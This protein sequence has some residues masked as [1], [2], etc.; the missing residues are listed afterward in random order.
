MLSNHSRVFVPAILGPSLAEAGGAQADFVTYTITTSGSGSLGSQVFTNAPLSLSFVGDTANVVNVQPNVFYN[1]LGRATVTI[2]GLGTATFTGPIAVYSYQ[3]GAAVGFFN[4][5][6]FSSRDNTLGILNLTSSAFV[7]YDLMTSFGPAA[8]SGFTSF[9]TA[10][11][12]T[13]RGAFVLPP[14]GSGT[15]TASLSA[16]PEPGSIVMLSTGAFGLIRYGWRR[17]HR[18]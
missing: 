1:S 16:V 7:R 17:R 5:S 4:G 13:D 10:G 9:T 8:G 11:F 14:P 12:A 6:S 2:V 3:P 18:V 15:F